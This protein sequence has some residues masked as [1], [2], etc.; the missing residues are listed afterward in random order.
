MKLVVAA[1][2][3][4]LVLSAPGSAGVVV[5]KASGTVSIE[6]A[7]VRLI[8]TKQNDGKVSQ[9]YFARKG[10]TWA[11]VAE[12]FAP[13]FKRP[14]RGGDVPPAN[15][16]RLFDSSV[17]RFRYLAAELPASVRLALGNSTKFAGVELVSTCR[18]A[19]VRQR[20][21]LREGRRH[22]HVDVDLKLPGKPAKLD[23][24]LSTFTFNLDRPP[25]FVHTPALKYDNAD[26]GQNRFRI[27]PG[28]DHIIGDRAFH[29]PAVILQEGGLFAALV[30]DLEAINRY[31]VPSPDARR[32]ID[33]PRN[34][35]SLPLRADKYTMPTGLDLNVKTGLTSKPVFSFGLMDSIIC[36]HIH[37]QRVND[38]SMVRTL[39][40][41]A[42]GYAFDLF[43]G[44]DVAPGSGFQRVARH[45]WERFG[46]PVFRR[47]P[48]LAMPFQD[49]AQLIA[50]V[51]LDG[52][53][54][55][56]KPVGGYRGTGSWLEWEID[57]LPVGG[58]CS[59]IP[60][61]RG[62]INN[63][64]YWNQAREAP[65]MYFW[66]RKLNAPKLIERSRRLV[67]FCLKA[68]RNEH[69]LF[70]LLYDAGSRKWSL[71]FSDPPHGKKG[72]FLRVSR[73]YSVPVM[74][75]TGAHLLDYYLRCGK[76][77]RIV[78]Y[79][80]PYANWLLSKI[81][82]RGAVPTYVTDKM[83]DSPIL[84]HSAHPAASMWFLA[85][86][87]NATQEAKYRAGARRIAAYTQKEIL[88]EAK[89]IDHE[90][91]SSCGAKPYTFV[92]DKWQN[93]PARANL[94]VI[95]AAEGF[96]ALHRATRDDRYLKAGE[97]CIDYLTFTQ[98]CWDP[99]YIYTAFPF[100]G[101]SVDN[102]DNATMLDARQAETAEPF[103]WYGKALGRQ[104]LLERGVAAARSSI[105]L[106]HHPRHVKNDIYGYP[107]WP[108]GLGPENIDHEAHP[109]SPMRTH[110]SW[111]ESSGVFT[112]LAE[113]CREL[114]GVYVH[115][116]KRLAVGA[117]GIR[118]KRV[119]FEQRK[120]SVELESWLAAKYLKMPWAKAFVTDLLVEGLPEKTPIAL[121]VNGAAVGTFHTAPVR[122]PLRVLPDGSVQVV[123]R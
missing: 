67:N 31:Q 103:I 102:S 83:V 44:A 115:Y 48:H 93:Q 30:P 74:S 46:H 40:K 113:A 96:A 47:R 45:Q 110:P 105:V 9:Q 33:I 49:Y 18:G 64:S 68:P 91:Y 7:H 111:G 55:V 50:R 26:S 36:H 24:A 99:H 75:K 81:D 11:L 21:A 85:E 72:Y 104:D 54:G 94:C 17:T 1:V 10:G 23:Y 61:F 76:D 62:V 42:I 89:W 34:K 82:D 116:N 6:N 27:L 77:G 37:Y 90:Q 8:L 32:K 12:S 5:K 43:V 15:A 106:I 60:F 58:F 69:G 79:L 63:T 80:R 97:R 39:S 121:T 25:T 120:L 86:F 100:G 122:I 70:A 19:V 95:W 59:P 41:N 114:G 16:V 53:K 84:Y 65:G 3:A 4:L 35:F 87:H 28:K 2:A 112:G 107:N 52:G 20:I 119:A 117:N 57:K 108:L 71:H 73:S 66:G 92:R 109:Q 88:P 118:V 38:A 56:G 101:S 29:A 98:C 22:F 78:A 13:V 14:A 123:P 51:V